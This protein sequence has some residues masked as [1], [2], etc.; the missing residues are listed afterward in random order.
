MTKSIKNAQRKVQFYKINALLI[1]QFE[2]V[3]TFMMGNGWF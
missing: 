2:G 1:V 3:S